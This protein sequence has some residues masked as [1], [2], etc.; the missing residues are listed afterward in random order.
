V[1]LAIK[2]R[3]ALIEH[4]RLPSLRELF[5]NE[6]PDYEERARNVG[7]LLRDTWERLVEEDLFYET[8]VRWRKS[9]ETGRLSAVTVEHNV[10]EDIHRGVTRTSNWT[11]DVAAG[12]GRAPPE[13]E[14]L[15]AEVRLIREC[16]K[17]IVSPREMI[18]TERRKRLE[19]IEA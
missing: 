2:D 14:D 16:R 1:I 3:L 13:P 7:K 5:K 10:W 11:H 9:V 4:K 8:V 18:R 17:L 6:A 19:P 15:E 12:S